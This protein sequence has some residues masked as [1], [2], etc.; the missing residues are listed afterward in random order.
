[1]LWPLNAAGEPV[2]YANSG[3]GVLEGAFSA[4]EWDDSDPEHPLRLVVWRATDEGP[5]RVEL[6]PDG[7]TLRAV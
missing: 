7:A 3:C 5:S 1:M 6:V 2:R 4:L